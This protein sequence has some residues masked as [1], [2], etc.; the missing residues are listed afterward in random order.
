[1][2]N[3][4]SAPF[5]NTA[6]LKNKWLRMSVWPAVAMV[7]ILAFA[8]TAYTHCCCK[9]KEWLSNTVMTKTHLTILKGMVESR[10]IWSI[11]TWR[12]K[13]PPLLV[14]DALLFHPLLEG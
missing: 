9:K 10:D 5:E 12:C 3:D 6:F 11:H 13:I 14:W 4:Y 2:R 1:M 8:R 7:G